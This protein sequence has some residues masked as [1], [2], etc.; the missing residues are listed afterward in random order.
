VPVRVGIDVVWIPLPEIVAHAYFAT[1]ERAAN[2][3]E[4]MYEAV[5]VVRGQIETNF[6]VEGRPA[7]WEPLSEATLFLREYEGYQS[8][9]ILQRSGTLKSGATSAAAWDIDSSGQVVSA[10]MMDP[11]GYGHFHVEGTVFQPIRDY[12]YVDD[13]ALDEID[14]LF[15]DWVT[16][17]F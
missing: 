10:I 9:P 2:M 1:A 17:E 15:L 6:D 3:L 4:P 12:T 16:E 11:T 8:G 5:E 7:K 13:E 14:N